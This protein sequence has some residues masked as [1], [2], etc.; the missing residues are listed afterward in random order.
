[1]KFIKNL[2]LLVTIS[3]VFLNLLIN[4][5][6]VLALY[7]DFNTYQKNVKY[8]P[9][10]T[11]LLVNDDGTFTICAD[12]EDE[13]YKDY[14]YI[15][16]FDKNKICYKSI[17]IKKALS[18]FGCFVK[19]NDNYYIFFGS[20]VNAKSD[21][22]NKNMALVKYNLKGEKLAECFFD[23]PFFTGTEIEK[24]SLSECKMNVSNNRLLIYFGCEISEAKTKKKLEASYV[25]IFD[26]ATFTNITKNIGVNN[27]FDSKS[28][29]RIILLE[30]DGFTI[31]DRITSYLSSFKLSKVSHGSLKS[32]DT[33]TLKEN[34][35]GDNTFSKLSGLLKTS[36]GYLIAGIKS[37]NVFVQK[38]SDDLSTKEALICITNY[39]DKTFENASNVKIVRVKPNK[40][41]LLWECKEE[42]RAYNGTYITIINDDGFIQGSIRKLENCSLS[43]NDNLVY[44]NKSNKVYWTINQENN[45]VT[46]ELNLNTDEL[47]DSLKLNRNNMILQVGTKD[48]L[49]PILDEEDISNKNVTFRSSDESIATINSNGEINAVKVGKADIFVTVQDDRKIAIS[50]CT[51]T[52]NMSNIDFE[53]KV[54][55][56]CNTERQVRG[57][58]LLK[59]DND[60]MNL[61]RIKS[62]D[63]IDENYFG[64][65]SPKYGNF[66]SMLSSYEIKFIQAAENVAEGQN[67]PEEVVEC[68]MGSNSHRSNILNAAFT[69]VG[70]GTAMDEN[71][72]IIWTQHFTKPKSNT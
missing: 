65:D 4:P 28:H 31:L 53:R 62:Q 12:P 67:T 50:K 2:N 17:E 35:K 5:T 29:D 3:V 39:Q 64:H 22:K 14:L 45:I 15:Y 54:I 52:V 42:S 21:K 38:I 61:A 27:L 48:L 58:P 60:L 10:C 19:Y 36:D 43:T 26:L 72:I 63:M 16:E 23:E 6:K 18:K 9:I 44:S 69:N 40:N 8:T 66:S 71:G 13:I 20:D 32:V 47:S 24:F 11:N 59:E 30:A 51:I 33:F 57:I 41:I 70:V 1:M 7:L 49:Q 55:E 25:S 37:K 46:Y 56:L 68:W 34:E